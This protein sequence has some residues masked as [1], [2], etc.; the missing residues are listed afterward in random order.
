MLSADIQWDGGW[1]CGGGELYGAME[2]GQE[3]LS[4]RRRYSI[5][6]SVPRE[7]GRPP[8]RKGSRIRDD[9]EIR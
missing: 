3:G 8:V 6:H 7:F 4:E 2:N 5:N 1:E 9:L